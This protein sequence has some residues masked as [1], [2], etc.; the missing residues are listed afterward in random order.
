MS[1][2]NEKLKEIFSLSL[3]IDNATFY[4]QK[5]AES[6]NV[7]TFAKGVEGYA[8]NV[9]FRYSEWVDKKNPESLDSAINKLKQ[10]ILSQP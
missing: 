4:H 10:I 5:T 1:S 3:K 6:G 9:E 2:I 8:I 7:Y